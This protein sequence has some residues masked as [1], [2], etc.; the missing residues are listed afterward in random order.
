MLKLAP[1]QTMEVI[2]GNLGV[3]VFL[4][5]KGMFKG[6]SSESLSAPCPA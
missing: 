6:F 2:Y 3:W 5:L 4:V 1:N